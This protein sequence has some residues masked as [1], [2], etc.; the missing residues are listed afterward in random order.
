[1]RHRTTKTN[2]AKAGA[3]EVTPAMIQ[4]G[5]DI[6][7]DVYDAVG[8]PVDRATARAKKKV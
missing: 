1:M 6:L 3:P 8:G 2:S 5:V 7:M 4:A